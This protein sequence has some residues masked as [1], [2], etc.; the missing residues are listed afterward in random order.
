MSGAD[1]AESLARRLLPPSSRDNLYAASHRPFVPGRTVFSAAVG[2]DERA[3]FIGRVRGHQLR[4]VQNSECNAWSA[5]RRRARRVR[6]NA[7][8][9]REDSPQRRRERTTEQQRCSPQRTPRAL[10]T[11]RCGERRRV[12]SRRRISDAAFKIQVAA[13]G[14]RPAL[15]FGAWDVSASIRAIRG[16][17]CDRSRLVRSVLSPEILSIL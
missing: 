4:R 2:R 16:R 8:Q 9:W 13:A 12:G 5:E 17:V 7:E 11:A 14:L 15:R 1:R 3:G 10:R 6:E